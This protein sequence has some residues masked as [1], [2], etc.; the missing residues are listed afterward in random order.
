MIFHHLDHRIN[1]QVQPNSSASNQRILTKTSTP[2]LTRH[3]KDRTAET[4]VPLA[5]I[6][7]IKSDLDPIS[8]LIDNQTT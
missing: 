6:C 3:G 5:Q 8:E 2:D 7:T 4:T 1:H